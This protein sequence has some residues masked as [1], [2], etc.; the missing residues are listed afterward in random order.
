MVRDL[1]ER[2][3]NSDGSL[4]LFAG[5]AALIVIDRLGRTGSKDP[6]ICA[7]LGDEAEVELLFR[8]FR[9]DN[10]DFDI[11]FIPAQA[12]K[13]TIPGVYD[14]ADFLEY[15]QKRFFEG[16]TFEVDIGE[17]LDAKE[18]LSFLYECLDVA[19]FSNTELTVVNKTPSDPRPGYLLSDDVYA[20]VYGNGHVIGDFE[21][22]VETFKENDIAAAFL[23][24]YSD[25]ESNVRF[26]ILL[27]PLDDKLALTITIF[28]MKDKDKAGKIVDRILALVNNLSEA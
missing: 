22:L 9:K 26:K 7:I 23:A 3:F 6:V 13:G 27:S 25:G 1:T 16:S 15:L 5:Q 21:T 17:N 19:E 24:D 28:D 11:K 14:Q 12:E 10:A 8:V 4:I 20:L 18:Y 2:D